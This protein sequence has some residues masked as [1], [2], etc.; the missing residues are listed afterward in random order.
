MKKEASLV[1][2]VGL[3]LS[4]ILMCVPSDRMATLLVYAAGTPDA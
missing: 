4:L 1:I 3:I 2:I